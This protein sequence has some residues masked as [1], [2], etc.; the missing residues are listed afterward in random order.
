MGWRAQDAR[1]RDEVEERRA[2]FRVLPLRRRLMIRAEQAMILAL[3]A[4]VILLFVVAFTRG[5]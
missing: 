2:E 1:D 4:V 3:M 5:V